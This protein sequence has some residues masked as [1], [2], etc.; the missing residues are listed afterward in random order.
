ME[1]KNKL[2]GD[3]M[4]TLFFVIGIGCGYIA[5]KIIAVLRGMESTQ[6][7][8]LFL[9]GLSGSESYRYKVNFNKRSFYKNVTY[10]I[11]VFALF[12]LLIADLRSFLIV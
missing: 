5:L 12:I 2:L 9:C 1:K 8:L 10:G 4:A 7:D 6:L 11:F 3:Q